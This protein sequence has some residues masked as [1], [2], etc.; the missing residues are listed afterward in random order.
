MKSIKT[1]LMVYFF[2]LLLTASISTG[3]VISKGANK[4]LTKE[5]EETL[6]TM[7]TEGSKFARSCIESQMRTLETIVSIEDIQDMDWEIQQPI[8]KRQVKNTGFLDIGIV[9]LD[10]IVYFSDGTTEKLGDE[11]YIKKA[12]K[13]ESN[14]SDLLIDGA[15]GKTTLMYVVPIKKGD[16]VVGALVGRGD[17]DY[18]SDIIVDIG[19]GKGMYAYI[20]NGEGRI[21]GHSDKNIVLSG[22]NPIEE[23]KKDEKLAALAEKRLME[24]TG[25]GKYFF[26]GSEIYS[27]Y[28]P[29]EG[30]DWIFVIS[31]DTSKILEGA[32]TLRR[33]III[34]AAT[35]IICAVFF[36]YFIGDSFTRPIIKGIK[37]SEEIAN[38][39]I[40]QNIPET[41]MKREDEIGI[42]AKALQGITNNLRDIIS[43]VNK[44]SEQVVATS[45]ELT[46]TTHEAAIAA[47]EVS[48]TADEISKGAFD[49]A[50]HT[51]EGSTKAILLG[52]TIEKEIE[53]KSDLNNAS[54]KVRK[55]IREGLVEIENLSNIIEESNNAA[56]EIHN[57]ILR[58]N[59]SSN[60][61]GQ[62]SNVISDIAEQTNLLAL[63]A[64]I[65]AAR[66]GESGRGFAVVAE[67]IRKLAE[68]SSAS[69]ESIN[70]IV[71]EL[72][73][74]TK[75]AVRTIERISDIVNEQ[76]NSVASSKDK[77]MLISEAM[78]DTERAVKQLN[79][80]GEKM[81]NMKKDILSTLENLSAIAEENSASTQQVTSSIEEQTASMEEIANASEDLATLAQDLQ[82]IIRKFTI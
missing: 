8:L 5:A 9:H 10:G 17:G 80:S 75:N 45:E 38:F 47:G 4:I 61:I 33:K 41:F 51:E 65:E 74:N 53:Y 3:L 78:E 76:T 14:V 67:E 82:L 37:H 13:G 77:Y 60:K 48:K 49:Q 28:T 39:D 26:N 58:T 42:L 19:K 12:F 72:Q 6:I 54:N 18:I 1:K 46:A 34:D 56:K 2:I 70:E 31:S 63:N 11:E 57:V 59:D 68:Q 16:K 32:S 40:S 36:V 71:S 35:N 66:A 7:A 27:G 55:V 64:A 79:I 23:A 52:E 73:N 25:V 15:A 81:E 24:K 22:Y 29:I 62:A 43:E 21:I 50:Q 44:S 20:A 30:T 69:T